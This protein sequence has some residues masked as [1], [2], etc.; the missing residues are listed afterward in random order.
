M[1]G[2]LFP[3]GVVEG[4]EGLKEYLVRGGY[5]ALEKALKGQNPEAIVQEVSESGL[6]GRGGAGFPTGKKMAITRE[7]AE[8]PHYVVLNGHGVAKRRT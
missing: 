4:R 1:E 2:I 5:K 6:R 7:C 8:Q 3:R